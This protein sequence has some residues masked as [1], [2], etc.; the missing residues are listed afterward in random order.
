[1]PEEQMK[2]TRNIR[3]L[4][5]RIQV[6]L[7]DEDPYGDGSIGWVDR[8]D[9]PPRWRVGFVGVPAEDVLAHECWHLF[10]SVM[11]VADSQPK[12]FDE[13]ACS[14]LYAYTFQELF[15]QLR[16]AVS[17]LAHRREKQ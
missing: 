3:F 11:A 14:E 4:N 5:F 2:R 8:L 1:M 13:L 17:T 10:N 7:C 9:N 15:S 6:I 12:A 16:Q